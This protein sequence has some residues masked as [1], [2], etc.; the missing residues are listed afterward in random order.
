MI[1][2]D[3]GWAL[4][5]GPGWCCSKRGVLAGQGPTPH[6][7][8][9]LCPPTRAGQRGGGQLTRSGQIGGQEGLNARPFT[10]RPGRASGAGLPFLL[11]P[12]LRAGRAANRA[13]F[14]GEACRDAP[15]PVSA[16]T[17]GGLVQKPSRAIR[18]S[19]RRRVGP[20]LPSP[21]LH[22]PPSPDAVQNAPPPLSL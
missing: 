9:R 22:G 2:D 3:N 17:F 11:S 10:Y 20:P 18:L 13:S 15:P 21:R 19:D 6:S 16:V 12:A 8:F 5:A 4:S 1:V 14:L 7:S